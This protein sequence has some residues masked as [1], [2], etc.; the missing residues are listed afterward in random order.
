MV[1]QQISVLEAANP[2]AMIPIAR[3]PDSRAMSVTK[4]S[5]T[6]SPGAQKGPHVV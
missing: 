1:L 3:H 4:S 5:G 2:T 6:T